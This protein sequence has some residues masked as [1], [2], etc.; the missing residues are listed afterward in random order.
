[1]QTNLKTLDPWSEV[2]KRI[3]NASS[4]SITADGKKFTGS[5]M[6]D[7]DEDT[8]HLSIVVGRP[9]GKAKKKGK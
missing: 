8:N 6:I 2:H 7:L 4:I 5:A 9:N 1:M 3:S